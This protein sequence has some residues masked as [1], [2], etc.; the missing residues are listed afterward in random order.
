MRL[1]LAT[2]YLHKRKS[3]LRTLLVAGQGGSVRNN[4]AA[5]LSKFICH[6]Y[7]IFL[8]AVSKGWW[9]EAGDVFVAFVDILFLI[10]WL[11]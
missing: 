3:N 10:C 7:F 5:S 8:F 4:G 9:L 11:C 1:K 2:R 6:F